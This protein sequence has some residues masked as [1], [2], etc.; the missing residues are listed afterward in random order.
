M[1]KV[2]LIPVFILTLMIGQVAGAAFSDVT[3]STSYASSIQWMADNGVIQGYPDGTFMPDQCVNRA[4]FLK[5]MYL[6]LGTNIIVSDAHA[7]SMYYADY[8]SDVSPEEWYWPYVDQGIR[9]EAVQ[10]YPDR[11]FKPGQCVNRA[12]AIKMA[13]VGFDLLNEESLNRGD[14]VYRDVLPGNNWFDVYIYSAVD[15]NA[16]GKDHVTQL[17]ADSMNEIYFHPGDSMSRKE[18]AEM[19]YRM[20]TLTDNSV[21]GYVD[22][23]SPNPLNY[24]VSPSNGVSFIMPDGWEVTSDNFYTTAGGVVA[25]YPSII[26][27]GTTD[28]GDEIVAINQRQMDCG[29][30]TYQATCFNINENYRIGSFSPSLEASYLINHIML[31]FREPNTSAS[32]SYNNPD[33]NLSFDIPEGW[34]LD[35]E[36]TTDFGTFS[37]LRLAFVN[38]ADPD[39][40]III[41]APPVETGYEGNI[42]TD[43]TPHPI[44]GLNE[45]T[46]WYATEENTDYVFVR[47]GYYVVD[48]EWDSHIEFFFSA[49]NANTLNDYM[50]D[51]YSMLDSLEF[52]PIA[53]IA[54]DG[55][56]SIQ[57]YSD[58]DWYVDFIGSLDSYSSTLP[59]EWPSYMDSAVDDKGEY[60]LALDNTMLIFI[61]DY[62]ENN[63]RRV[64]KYEIN[65][66]TVAMASDNGVYDAREFGAR[67]GD[68]I[69]VYGIDDYYG[70]Q[71]Q[72][73]DYYYLDNRVDT[74]TATTCTYQ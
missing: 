54:F 64:F 20:K 60:C 47:N 22:T 5:M 42:I 40:R 3:T 28:A 17:A 68:F 43:G 74:S 9:D 14:N 27:E 48:N 2:F 45:E 6:T 52:T 50:P 32:N 23:M 39:L 36:E 30:E 38:E 51:Y 59:G 11:T 44:Q 19:L 24:Y 66:N 26:I 13:V 63:T 57:D 33:F 49:P 16:V 12:E 41:N 34:T 37:Q 46:P 69:P 58:Q 31:T 25:D 53:G 4:E 70:C 71:Y 55:C 56:G 72:V 8:F 35:Q 73:G 7:G 10:G 61:P 15:R 62:T 65:K 21:F 29:P 18:V 1:K 67:D